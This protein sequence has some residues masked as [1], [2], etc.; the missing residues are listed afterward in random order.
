MS[1]V[2][3]TAAITG[4]IHT[5]TMTPYLPITPKQI[6]D[7]AVK[8]H[9]AGAAIVHIHVRN[10]E[11]GQPSSS[12]DLF[13]EVLTDIKSRCDVVICPT[14]G[15][16]LGMAPADRVRVVSQ[17]KPEIAS[18]TPGSCNFGLFPVAERIKDWKFDWEQ[19]YLASTEDLI[20]ANPFSTVREFAK[21]FDKA[22]TK[23]E[24][25]CFDVGMVQTSAWLVKQG[26]L[27]APVH[28]QFVIG[29]LGG[30]NAT[31]E[32]LM[33]MHQ[34]AQ[35]SLGK[36]TW[37]CL[38]PGGRQLTTVTMAMLMGGNVRVGLE[39]STYAGKGVMAKSSADQVVKITRIANELDFEIATPDEARQIIGLKGSDKVGF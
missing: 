29:I 30:I 21:A 13:H 3:I 26:W 5:P 39:D 12:L 33:M 11:T 7:D 28:M 1:K 32:S 31:P 18:F 10:P 6:A 8:A 16:G 4:A 14:T 22:G 19:K 38:G 36:Y 25:E 37:S 34:T 20:F 2:I 17:L 27:K 24:L 9:E 35:Q 15:G 23:P